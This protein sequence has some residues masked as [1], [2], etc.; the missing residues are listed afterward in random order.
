MADFENICGVFMDKNT[1]FDQIPKDVCKLIA[2]NVLLQPIIAENIANFYKNNY[3][4][5]DQNNDQNND[6]EE[7]ENQDYN[8]V[9]ETI[10]DNNDT[11]VENGGML[12]DNYELLKS[13]WLKYISVKLPKNVNN[14]SY[15]EFLKMFYE[16][17][18]L[19][20]INAALLIQPKNDQYDKKL[21]EKMRKR[22]IKN[23]YDIVVKNAQALYDIKVIIDS[24]NI[25]I[26]NIPIDYEKLEN[27]FKNV[28][29]FEQDA[30]YGTYVSHMLIMKSNLKNIR[31]FKMFLEYYSVNCTKNHLNNILNH[32][33]DNALDEYSD[34]QQDEIKYIID[35]LVEKG[36]DT[37]S[38]L[39]RIDNTRSL[40][41]LIFGLNDLKYDLNKKD[42]DGNTF[43]YYSDCEEDLY[44]ET[45]FNAGFDFNSKNNDGET[46]L[47]Y[48]IKTQNDILIQKLLPYY[49]KNN[50][51]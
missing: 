18:M 49:T 34:I 46:A 11:V 7:D 30:Y 43:I 14:L 17:F 21:N 6:N 2:A 32:V 42:D 23:K 39:L 28:V 37:K 51:M 5:N 12:Y 27:A 1:K 33:C 38:L 29:Y 40:N 47:D 15:N 44:Y 41:I 20:D 25:N 50:I 36:A 19:Y 48:A 22:I 13:L 45:A 10:L 4:N 31:L 9:E 16:A 24:N 35:L 26:H 8:Y 3:L